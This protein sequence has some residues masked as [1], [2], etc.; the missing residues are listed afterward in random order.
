MDAPVLSELF[1]IWASVRHVAAMISF[2][3]AI[4]KA[5]L[6]LELLRDRT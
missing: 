6:L 5:E 4:C 3:A 1:N 2:V